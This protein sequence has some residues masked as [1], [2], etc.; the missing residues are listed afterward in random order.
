M[1]NALTNTGVMDP[2]RIELKSYRV[3]LPLESLSIGVDNIHH[4]VFLSP[5]FVQVAR[6]YLFDLIRQKNSGAYLSG[7][8][9]RNTKP[10]DSTAFRKL[11]T[12]ILQSSLTMAKHQKNIEIDL[13]FRVA[14]LKFLAAELLNQ[15]GNVLL[16]GK[17][18]IRKRGEYFER[19]QQAHVIKAKLSEMQSARRDVLRLIGQLVAQILTDIEDNIIA[20]TRR[21]L[22][23][24]DFAPYYEILKNRLVFLDGGK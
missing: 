19:S 22:F 10:V 2:G 7:I 3:T 24:D 12:Q 8:E 4:D 11:L 20:K 16:E 21:A 23:G 14:L 15:F 6:D 1:A 5:K 9:F 17:E 18:Y 13:L